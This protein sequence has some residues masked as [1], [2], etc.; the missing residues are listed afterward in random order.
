MKIKELQARRREVSDEL[1]ELDSLVQF[2]ELSAEES[3]K[4][5]RLSREYDCVSRELTAAIQDAQAAPLTREPVKS[6][7][8]VLRETLQGVRQGRQNREVILGETGDGGIQDSGAVNLNIHDVLPTLNEGLSLP[9]GMSIVTGVVGNEIWPVSLDDAEVEEIGEVAELTDQSLTF[10]SIQAAPHR[11][12]LSVSISNAAIDNA[13]FDLLG[14]VQNKF[15]LALSKYVAEKLY[16]QAAWT[17][18]KGPFSGATVA[19]TIAMDSTAYKSILKAVADF[20]D[21]GYC[22]ANVCLVMDASTEADLKATPKADG[23]GGFVIENGKCAG[24]NYVVSH[25]INTKL[26]AS[27]ALESTTDKHIGIGLFD[28]EAVQQHGQVRLTVDTTSKAVAAKNTTA[29][30]LNTLFSFTDLS[31]KTTTNGKKN[32]TSTAFALYKV[33]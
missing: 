30:V 14:F 20:T 8:Q 3:A 9:A 26:S 29:V 18:N 5:T 28:Y 2:R 17:G 32:T 12:G 16:S 22:A 6:K 25:Y 13:A 24:Y 4:Q 19:G 27:N 31:A 33:G 11:V 15:T 23:Q 10:D 21:R 1:A 7:N